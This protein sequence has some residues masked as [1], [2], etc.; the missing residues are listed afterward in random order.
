MMSAQ[1]MGLRKEHGAQIK[2]AAL[3]LFNRPGYKNT[4]SASAQAELAASD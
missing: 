4:K 2:F 1:K 3:Q